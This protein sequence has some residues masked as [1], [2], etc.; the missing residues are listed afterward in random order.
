VI[1]ERCDRHRRSE[2]FLS[3]EWFARGPYSMT[4]AVGKTTDYH[5]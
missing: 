1:R 4:D 5:P 3:A 2:P